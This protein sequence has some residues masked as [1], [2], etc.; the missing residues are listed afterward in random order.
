MSTTTA[1]LGLNIPA[2]GE[3]PWH[4]L[5]EYNWNHLDDVIG[6]YLNTVSRPRFKG[7]ALGTLA[8]SGTY[9]GLEIYA[10][11]QK[12]A[13]FRSASNVY[14]LLRF[15]DVNTTNSTYKVAVGSNND[16]LVVFAAGVETFKVCDNGSCRLMPKSG[17]APSNP[18]KGQIYYD[19]STNHFYGYTGSSWKQ[20]DNT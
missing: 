14:S 15:E 5:Y 9:V 4:S 8:H 18:L 16:N 7:L 1:K 19:D 17:G 6:Q 20:L 2:Y 3:T 10:F 11:D 13:T 12:C